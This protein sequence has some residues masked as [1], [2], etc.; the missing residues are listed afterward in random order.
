MRRIRARFLFGLE[1]LSV[2]IGTAVGVRYAFTIDRYYVETNRESMHK[3]M[4][5]LNWKPWRPGIDP[6]RWTA[7]RRHMA[8]IAALAPFGVGL[9]FPVVRRILNEGRRSAC[10]PGAAA[11]LVG[12]A[13]LLARTIECAIAD[14]PAPGP[15]LW[16]PKGHMFL[17]AY[18]DRQVVLAIFGVWCW[19]AVAGTWKIRPGWVERL[20]RYYGYAW[21]ALWSWSHLAWPILWG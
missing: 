11:V 3:N 2:L 12:V 18:Y 10:S 1:I 4:N 17:Y 14:L 15:P 7:N 8:A 6:W 9:L 5:E 13:L 21:L 20:G 19:M 16:R